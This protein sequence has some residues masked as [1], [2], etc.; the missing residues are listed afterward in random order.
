M[1]YNPCY[2]RLDKSGKHY[3]HWHRRASL[4][5]T[6]VLIPLKVWFFYISIFLLHSPKVLKL[7]IVNSKTILCF[8]Q[9]SIRK[10][11]HVFIS[12]VSLKIN[13]E[14]RGKRPYVTSDRLHDFWLPSSFLYEKREFDIRSSHLGIFFMHPKMIMFSCS[15][16]PIPIRRTHREPPRDFTLKY[17]KTY[18]KVVNNQELVI[19]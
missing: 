18:F 11:N 17:V 10:T 13:E 4:W 15:Q 19:N 3:L 6:N 1:I 2:E 12:F 16:S 14:V 5:V 9:M 8:M 7:I